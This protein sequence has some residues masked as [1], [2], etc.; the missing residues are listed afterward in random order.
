M[1]KSM[2]LLQLIIAVSMILAG[3][4]HATPILWTLDSVSFTDCG[5]ATG[6]FVY[7]SDTD[8]YGSISIT[9]SGGFI[10]GATYLAT[11]ELNQPSL[12]TYQKVISSSMR[13][14]SRLLCPN[15]P[16]YSC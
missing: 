8:L 16:Q 1:R 10:A 13:A 6:S 11:D 9:T 3:S 12:A 2:K 5:V 4:V 14:Y 15:H 7:D